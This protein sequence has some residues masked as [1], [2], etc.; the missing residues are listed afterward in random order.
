MPSGKDRR[1]SSQGRTVTLLSAVLMAVV[2]G[3]TVCGAQAADICGDVNESGSLT[4]G[5]ALMVLKGAVGQPV[6]LKCRA[7][8]DLAI[9]QAATCGNDAAEYGEVCDGGD[10]RG[11]TCQSEAPDTPYGRLACGLN[12]ASL[13]TSGC[14]ARFTDN[15][16][17]TVTDNGTNLMWE[18]K[19]TD[20]DSGADA[21]NPHDVDNTYTWSASNTA[22]TGTV[23]TDFLDKLNG[24]GGPET[25][26]AGY[27]DWRLP[28]VEE[29][30]SIRD[31]SVP[32]CGSGSACIDGALAPAQPDGYWSSTSFP[33]YPLTAWCID[34]SS[35][36]PI[37][38]SKTDS[39]FVRAVRKAS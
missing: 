1:V 30:S 21:S 20:L 19:D 22:A 37:N 12:C 9:C 29:L 15:G 13:D 39:Y 35:G 24:Q 16:D 31:N 8:T 27:Y 4:A 34:F 10:L 33:G 3:G 26:F 36:Q 23:F 2:L 7:I 28:T 14:K 25:G 38:N 6:E 11:S 18:K 5:D 17:G 32:G